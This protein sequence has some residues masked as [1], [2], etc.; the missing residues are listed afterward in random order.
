[1]SCCNTTTWDLVFPSIPKYYSNF[2]GWTDYPGTLSE[3]PW[4][5]CVE[6][7]TNIPYIRP[8]RLRRRRN[9]LNFL[10][11]FLMFVVAFIFIAIAFKK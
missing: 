10:Q 11:I 6:N 8:Q 5:E 3:G 7:M 4:G 2:F 9:Q 1:M